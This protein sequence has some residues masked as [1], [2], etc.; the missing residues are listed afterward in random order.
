[1]SRRFND[2]NETLRRHIRHHIIETTSNSY[3][4]LEVP[5][6]TK[7]TGNVLMIVYVLGI[8]LKFS[9]RAPPEQR[10]SL[11]L[12]VRILFYRPETTT[13][14]EAPTYISKF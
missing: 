4:A 3:Q 9:A 5:R 13:L 1:M 7:E 14:Y 8:T 6:E 12:L 2:D 11:L 10:I